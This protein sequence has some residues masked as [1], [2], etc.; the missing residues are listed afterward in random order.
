MDNANSNRWHSWYLA[1]LETKGWVKTLRANASKA[2]L[3]RGVKAKIREACDKVATKTLQEQ[4]HAGRF[5]L[6]KVPDD[7]INDVLYSVDAEEG[8]VLSKCKRRA[9]LGP[10]GA[11]TYKMSVWDKVKLWFVISFIIDYVEDF[12]SK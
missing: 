5:D 8:T 3:P 2:M 11:L 1:Q 10:N 4:L 12:L 7:F 9:K 6:S